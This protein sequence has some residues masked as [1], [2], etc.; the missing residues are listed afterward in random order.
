[1]GDVRR[2]YDEADA[3]VVVGHI[4]RPFGE[5]LDGGEVS[6]VRLGG[7][8]LLDLVVGVTV[9]V[10]RRGAVG[11]DPRDVGLQR[12]PVLSAVDIEVGGLSRQP[13]EGVGELTGRLAG[14]HAAEHDPLDVDAARTIGLGGRPHVHGAG[15][16]AGGGDAT[17]V[18][19]LLVDAQRQCVLAIDVGLDYGVPTLPE[20]LLH[21]RH[22][23]AGVHRQVARHDQQRLVVP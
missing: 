15:C 12:I 8:P 16:S 14:L 20:V 18:L 4:A 11:G 5:D 19:V 13:L 21:L 7:D 6:P 10:V 3:V 17:E 1:M 23:R 9:R 2:Q 22:E